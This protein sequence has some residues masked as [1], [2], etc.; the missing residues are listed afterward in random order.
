MIKA[1]VD[2]NVWVSALLNPGTARQIAHCLQTYQFQLVCSE[3]LV[4]ELVHVLR[5]P[6]I[7]ITVS[8]DTTNDF[9]GLLENTALFVKIEQIPTVS[10]DPKDNVYLACAAVG[11]CDFLVTG[12]NDLLVL[13]TYGTTKIVTP[14]EFLAA[15]SP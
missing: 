13:K 14:A 15:L 10:R 11:N 9:I 7:A 5:R 3:Q 2:A 4:L 6:K 1:V 12:D 8:K